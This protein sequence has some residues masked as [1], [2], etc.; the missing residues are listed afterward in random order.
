MTKRKTQVEP[1]S[2]AQILLNWLLQFVLF[3]A[4]LSAALGFAVLCKLLLGILL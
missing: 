2:Y 4:F 3:L 1:L